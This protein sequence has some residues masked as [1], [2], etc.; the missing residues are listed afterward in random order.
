MYQDPLESSH[1]G[2]THTAL[3]IPLRVGLLG[4]GTVGSGTL[5]VLQRNAALIAARSGRRIEVRQ[6]AVRD[7]ER[8]R[9]RMGAALQ[10]GVQL[11]DDAWS[12]VRHPDI[13]VVVETIGGT[14][15]ARALVLEAIA[16]GKHVVTANKALLAEHGSEIFA[17][18]QARGVVVAYEG[19][20]AVSIPI[21]KALRE[22][23]SGN[24]IEWLAGIINGTSNFILTAMREQGMGFAQALALAQEKGYAEA[25]PAF[26]VQGVDAAHKLSLL[27]ANAFGTPP[28]FAQVHTEGID[29]LEGVDVDFAQRL[30]YGVKLLG[31]A[32]RCGDALELRVHPTLLPQGHL[33]AQVHGSMNAIMVHSDAAGTTLFYGAG[34]GSEQTGSAVVADLVDLAR[35]AQVAAALRVPALAF[36]PGAVRPAPVLDDGAVRSAFYVRLDV[37]RFEVSVPQVLQQLALEG[38]RVQR[39]EVLA[40]PQDSTLRCLVLLTEVLRRDTLDTALAAVQ[41][42]PTVL[43]QAQVLRLETLG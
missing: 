31:I 16:Q 12:V 40:H 33:L 9:A 27:A 14:T 34:A 24:R 7:L 37:D 35:S 29:R 18:A 2:G 17:A 1:Y 32:R 22:G 28:Q 38:V 23:L 5:A 20:V 13:D 39:M 21:I 15:A 26:D 11:C 8:A 19:A 25:D 36:Q 10:G 42:W 3:S 41:H 30:G 4:L 43:G 6:V